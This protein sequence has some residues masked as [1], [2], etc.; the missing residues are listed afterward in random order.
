V[1]L[2]HLTEYLSAK[3]C[4]YFLTSPYFGI[5]PA[6]LRLFAIP[7]TDIA[8]ADLARLSCLTALVIFVALQ[9]RMLLIVHY[10]L[11]TANRRSNFSLR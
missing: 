7:F 6:A 11:P 2:H 10:S 3:L 1:E 8:H 9:L 4:V 5:F